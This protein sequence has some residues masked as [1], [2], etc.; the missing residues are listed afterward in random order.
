MNRLFAAGLAALMTVAAVQARPVSTAAGAQVSVAAGIDAYLSGLVRAGSF[1]GS[2]LIAQNGHVIL[3]RGYGLADRARRLGDGPVTK[4]RIFDLTRE[5]TAVA[6]LELQDEGKLSV[7][8]LLCSYVSDCP[9]RWKTVTLH[10]LLSNSSGI[11]NFA[12][13]RGFRDSSTE[14]PAQIVEMTR[15]RPLL[16]QPGSQF[17]YSATDYVLLGLVIQAVSGE[18]YAAFLRQHVLAPLDLANSGLLTDGMVVSHLARGYAD[19]SLAKRVDATTPWA[20]GGMFSTVKDLYLWDQALAAGKLLTKQA[21]QE[22]FTPYVAIP[23]ETEIGYGYGW[24]IGPLWK[25]EAIFH[26]GGSLGYQSVN[27]MF[28]G[29]QLTI[30]VLSNLGDTDVGSIES[31]VVPRLLK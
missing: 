27:L 3:D 24:L 22:M 16:F 17:G 21:L 30:I 6:I 18:S 10:E 1:Q 11:P 13:L 2:V 28:P 19:R 20:A 8:G 9:D 31:V 25:H 14:T 29:K 7:Q 12:G 4:Y 15:G 5:F 26:G 23:P